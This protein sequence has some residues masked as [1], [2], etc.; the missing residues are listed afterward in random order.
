MRILL[1]SALGA[2]AAVSFVS[3]ADQV[4]PLDAAA[5]AVAFTP[6]GHSLLVVTADRRA[7]VWDFASGSFSRSFEP[8]K[9][10]RRT[11]VLAT[12]G[13]FATTSSTGAVK[14]REVA[15]GRITASF[16]I[17]VA[18]SRI[19]ALASSADGALLAISGGDPAASS[20]T[21]IRVVDRAGQPRFASSA[22]LGSVGAMSFSPDGE[23]LVVA[24]YDT[25]LRVWDVRTGKLQ[26]RLE[27][28]PLAMF[29]V[30]FSPDG[31]HL[32]TAGADRVIYL[33]DTKTWKVVRKIAGQPETVQ[34]IRFSPDGTKLVSGGMNELNF[35]SPVKVMLWDVPTGRPLQTWAAEHMVVGLAF[36]PDGRQVAVADGSKQVKL[37]AVP[38]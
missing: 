32:A 16:T 13:H 24:G 10:D 21:L 2:A 23:T 3:G 18:G 8:E 7:R 34:R 25:D 4:I 15:S 33:W 36:S 31:K 30:V 37:W 29:D 6:D 9:D 38:K 35:D 28:M 27:E 12:A 1:L 11:V 17:Q 20:A 5:A 26:H 14:V 22:G 19:G